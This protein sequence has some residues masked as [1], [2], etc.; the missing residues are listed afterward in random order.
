[1][2]TIKKYKDWS[3]ANQGLLV[4]LL[5]NG[6]IKEG[7]I[8]AI[9]NYNNL[10]SEK[11]QSDAFRRIS[12]EIKLRFSKEKLDK[13]RDVLGNDLYDKFNKARESVEKLSKKDNL[14]SSKLREQIENAFP[15]YQKNPV[16]K[17]IVDITE[18]MSDDRLKRYIFD[19]RAYYNKN[20][21]KEVL[22]QIPD[23]R[24][25]LTIKPGYGVRKTEKDYKKMFND[26]NIIDNLGKYSFN[27]IDYVAR[28]NGLTGKELLND[29]YETKKEKDRI[30]A[31]H[32]D[33]ADIVDKSKYQSFWNNPIADNVGG[34]AL[35]L[36]GRR[37]QEAI[38]RGE[39]P[40]ARDYIGDVGENLMYMTPG[41]AFGKAG[42]IARKASSIG[43]SVAI[44][45]ISEVYDAAVY[46]DG[47]RGEVSPMDIVGGT[48][49]NIG[50][51]FM[52]KKSLAGT[53]RFFGAKK[54]AEKFEKMGEGLTP[55]ETIDLNREAQSAGKKFSKEAKNALSQSRP[56]VL[57]VAESEGNSIE[58]KAKNYLLNNGYDPNKYKVDFDATV[59]RKKD[60]L[61]TENKTY[62]T[63]KLKEV[64]SELG[65]N[66]ALSKKDLLES[67]GLK[68]YATNKFGDYWSESNE[69]LRKIPFVGG[70]IQDVYNQ[71]LVDKKLEEEQN[72]SKASSDSIL[73]AYY[74][75]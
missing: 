3:F 22:D 32:G 51:P 65:M 59:P 36:F 37:Q 72:K 25:Y 47:S 41:G 16:L 31:A 60:F 52:L 44:P 6:A 8:R 18:P 62:T 2:A 56:V 40:S 61:K 43:S 20:L 46:D 64:Y 35:S 54:A 63:P 17:G 11:E 49:T 50:S 5:N 53:S 4:D 55:N 73:R 23:L 7:D 70:N 57:E 71:Y 10:Y 28:K 34:L 42:S 75:L 15:D 9:N 66:D 39:D 1:M 12:D 67:E 19:T 14:L 13:D 27:D 30:K 58:E 26:D 48:L 68:T 45:T 38:E 74:G 21:G 33:I 24:E 69:P 29:L